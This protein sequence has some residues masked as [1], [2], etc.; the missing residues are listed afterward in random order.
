MVATSQRRRHPRWRMLFTVVI[1]S[2]LV[3]HCE[4]ASTR[5]FLPYSSSSSSSPTLPRSSS[6]TRSQ[7]LGLSSDLTWQAWILL[8]SQP[9]AHSAQD[10]AS[11][12]R[13]I[14]PKSVFIAPAL[15]VLPPCAEGYHADSMAR[16][17][18]DVS[19]N[20]QAHLDFLLQK[21]NNRYASNA[22]EPTHNS[23]KKSSGPLQ[24]N[25]P[26]LSRLDSQP[27][28]FDYEETRDSIREPIRQSIRDP[29][30]VQPQVEAH[31]DRDH[32]ESSE[33][34][35]LET[36]NNIK[37]E[38]EQT[39]PLPTTSDDLFSTTFDEDTTSK[40]DT[41]APTTEDVDDATEAVSEAVSEE[42][43]LAEL[44]DDANA[45]FSEAI[46][47]AEFVDDANGTDY[48]EVVEYKIPSDPRALLDARF[49]TV[50]GSEDMFAWRNESQQSW[51]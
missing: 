14:T 20:K 4:Q 48:S 16:C 25:I 21:L 28:K 23:Q 12:R 22:S 13:R 18:K 35:I 27:P 46:P 51:T 33:T 40:T 9:S 37:L 6:E 17:M 11:F 5:R 42:V 24:L 31:T 7:N 8:D 1:L 10:S 2:V 30:V 44:F 3:R 36:T 38:E 39:T 34:T 15:P 26:L 45:N 49:R 19:I 41:V 43:P 47:V 29:I 50:N 32:Q